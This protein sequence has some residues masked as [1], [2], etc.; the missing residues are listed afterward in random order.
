MRHFADDVAT[1]P[2]SPLLPILGRPRQGSEVLALVLEEP[3]EEVL[4]H[5][6]GGRLRPHFRAGC[7]HCIAGAEPPKPLYYVGA[8]AVDGG[9]GILELT[10]KCLAGALAAAR[11]L[12]APGGV[13]ALGAAL[14]AAPPAPGLTGC[15]VKVLRADFPRSPRVLRCSQRLADVPAWPYDTRRELARIWGVPVRPRLYRE[16]GDAG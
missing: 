8:A 1:G 10:P 16:G 6:A 15:L 14:A 13:E 3:G 5:F 9:L 4:L 11:R 2:G 12:P 7:P